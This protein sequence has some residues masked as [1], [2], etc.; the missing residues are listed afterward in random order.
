MS[1]LLQQTSQALQGAL[2]GHQPRRLDYPGSRPAA[3]LMPLWERDGRVQMVF[4]KRNADLPHHPGQISFPGGA[5]DPEDSGLSETALRETC[6]E[7][8]VCQGLVEVVGRLDQV[9]TITNFLVTPYL[10][11]V[12][13]RADF[14]PNP[15]EVERLVVVPLAKV[16]DRANYQP[17]PLQWQGVSMQQV[18]LTHGQDVIWGA[19]ARMLLNLLDVLGEKAAAV[20][21]VAG[22][23]A[24]KAVDSR[25]G[26][27]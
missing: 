15:V 9:L 1:D 3:V 12:D 23:G 8:G 24:Q 14:R 17:R 16:L 7:I 6:E 13:A 2:A 22:N 19:T 11:L 20:A 26:L 21:A 5:A 10:G 4:T 27:V 18:A 25:R